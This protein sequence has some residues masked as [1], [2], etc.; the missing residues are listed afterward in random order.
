MSSI[1]YLAHSE[2]HGS[3]YGQAVRS[4]ILAGTNEL[5]TSRTRTVRLGRLG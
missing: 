1:S 3:F 4:R 5:K 2:P